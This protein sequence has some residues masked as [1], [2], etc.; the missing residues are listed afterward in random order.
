MIVLA[1]KKDLQKDH[2]FWSMNESLRKYWVLPLIILNCHKIAKQFFEHKKGA[3]RRTVVEDL[4]ARQRSV[5]KT[6]QHLQT[7]KTLWDVPDSMGGSI[8]GGAVEDT[9]SGLITLAIMVGAVTIITIF[10]IRVSTITI[11]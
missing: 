5:F 11:I 9:S 6:H 1:F 8:A 2:N 7:M 4:H 10:T 3:Q